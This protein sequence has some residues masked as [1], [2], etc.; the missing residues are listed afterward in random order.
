MA[1]GRGAFYALFPLGLLWAAVDGRN[2]SVQD[3]V[4]RTSVVYDWTHRVPGAEP[5]A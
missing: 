1:L 3:L 4:L 2:R 5:Q